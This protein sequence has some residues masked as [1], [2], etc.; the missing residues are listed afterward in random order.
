LAGRDHWLGGTKVVFAIRDRKNCRS[1]KTPRGVPVGDFLMKVVH[2][3]RLNKFSPLDYFAA[4][5]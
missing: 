2:S 4:R 3:C 5:R 1:D